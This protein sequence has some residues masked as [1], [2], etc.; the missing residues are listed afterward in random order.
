[1]F[2]IQSPSG[3]PLDLIQ[4]GKLYKPLH[5]DTI[6]PDRIQLNPK[7]VP[8]QKDN[9]WE[10][11]TYDKGPKSSNPGLQAVQHNNQVPNIIHNNNKNNQKSM[12]NFNKDG[13]SMPLIFKRHRHPRDHRAISNFDCWKS[14]IYD[15]HGAELWR[16]PGAILMKR[17]KLGGAMKSTL[18]HATRKEQ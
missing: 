6:L 16:P 14:K 4:T 12:V 7:S 13:N 17:R 15:S 1:M 10:T 3:S 8:N 2:Q 18:P 9:F 11:L 5:K